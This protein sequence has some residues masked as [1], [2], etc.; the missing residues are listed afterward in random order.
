MHISIRKL[1]VFLVLPFLV[2]VS[3]WGAES[4]VSSAQA[5]FFD[6]FW[7]K[8]ASQYAVL[9]ELSGFEPGAKV[10]Y[11]I[12]GPGKEPILNAAQ[13]NQDGTLLVPAPAGSQIQN[14]NITYDF[15]INEA[16]RTVSLLL[17]HN[18]LTGATSLN[19]DTDSP[20]TDVQIQAQDREIQKRSDW[21]GL[22]EETGIKLKADKDVVQP[23]QIA[24]YS[25]DIATDARE[26]A[27][28][29]L[30]KILIAPGGRSDRFGP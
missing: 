20:F 27:S 6:K 8:E 21:A 5:S 14:K 11:R 29:A 30:I 16:E 15:S 10:S 28:P 13:I 1:G 4:Y 9:A 2:L 12:T 18:A 24:F 19:G 26:Y 25:R 3:F 23:V 22:F 17:R 7:K